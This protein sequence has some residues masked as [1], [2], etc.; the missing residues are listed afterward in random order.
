MSYNEKCYCGHAKKSHSGGYI[1]MRLYSG[2]K[3]C[4]C[5][6]YSPKSEGKEEWKR[7]QRFRHEGY[8]DPLPSSM[9]DSERKKK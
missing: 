9:S 1:G 6:Q 5:I 3:T 7:M 2:C 8:G 4:D